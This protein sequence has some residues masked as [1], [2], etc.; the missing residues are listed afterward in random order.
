MWFWQTLMETSSASYRNNCNYTLGGLG[1]VADVHGL[2]D[3][4]D[5]VKLWTGAR[6]VVDLSSYYYDDL[7]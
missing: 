1:I 3:S 4:R 5:C 7:C 6:V 2:C